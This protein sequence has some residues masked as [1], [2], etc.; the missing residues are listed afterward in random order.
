ME[1]PNRQAVKLLREQ[2]KRKKRIV[3]FLCMA[4][5]VVVGTVM[6]LR[7]SGRA[8]NNMV[9]DCVL[10]H[11]LPHQHSE[12]CYYTPPGDGGQKTL[13]C[14][15]ADFVVHKHDQENC[16][17]KNGNLVCMLPEIEE[18]IHTAECYQSQQV[19]VCGMQEGEGGHVHS[20][21]CY[22]ADYS[23]EPVCGLEESEGHIHDTETCYDD[24]GQLVC[25]L[26]ETA[27]HIH[28]DN[29]YP[30]KLNCGLE[31]GD[32]A[33]IHSDAC[34][35]TEDILACGKN[36]VHLHTHTEECYLHT[37]D[38]P[39]EVQ[40]QE[41]SAKG[42][43][44]AQIT[45]ADSQDAPAEENRIRAAD[46]MPILKCGQ[47]Q[48]LEHVH[49]EDCY[50][51]VGVEGDMLSGLESGSE[52]A[53]MPGQR[54]A[55]YQDGTLRA[56]A[57][58]NGADFPENARINVERVDES[59]RLPEKQ[60]QFSALMQ[61]D[62]IKLKALLK[63]TVSGVDDTTALSE[64]I[65]LTIEPAEQGEVI[66]AAWYNG[67]SDL[68]AQ[69]IYVKSEE[70]VRLLEVD[71]QEGN[72]AVTEV[73]P[74]VVAGFA[75][76]PEAEDDNSGSSDGTN[77]DKE[78]D[79][80]QGQNAGNAE[81]K[82]VLNISQDFEYE[83][84]DYMMVF[85]ISGVAHT[86]EAAPQPEET[87]EP[88]ESQSEALDTQ[89]DE[90]QPSSAESSELEDEDGESSAESNII[91]DNAD[92][93][94]FFMGD[95]GT[96]GQPEYPEY[97]EGEASAAPVSTPEPTAEPE[98]TA[99]P[100]WDDEPAEETVTISGDV[101]PANVLDDPENPLGLM[102][103]QAQ[104]GTPEYEVYAENVKTDNSENDLPDLKVISYSLYYKGSELD[105]TQCAVELDVTAKKRLI[106]AALELEEQNTEAPEE[107]G[108]TKVAMA[109]LVT[110]DIQNAGDEEAE[111]EKEIYSMPIDGANIDST[112]AH[113]ETEAIDFVKEQ[114][115]EDSKVSVGAA[116]TV[117]ESGGVVST[118]IKARGIDGDGRP[119]FGMTVVSAE[120]PSF[121]V[122]Y[123]AWLDK[124]KIGDTGTLDII[125]TDGNGLPQNGTTPETKK[126]T[127][128]GD[129]SVAIDKTMTQIYEDE[130][131]HYFERPSLDYFAPKGSAA[132][133]Y[134]IKQIWVLRKEFRE[135][136]KADEDFRNTV[137]NA[138]GNAIKT[139]WETYGAAC[140]EGSN[141]FTPEHSNINASDMDFT[142]R[143][144]TADAHPNYLCITSNDVIRLVYEP[145]RDETIDV[146][147]SFFDYDISDGYT[148]NSDVK[149]MNTAHNGINTP[150][151]YPSGSGAEYAF[152]NKN[153]GTDYGERDWNGNKLN[154]TNKP[155][156]HAGCTFGLV[157]GLKV[158][159]GAKRPTPTFADGV[160]APN[161][162]GETAVNGK[163]DYSGNLTFN[164]VGDT[165]TLSIA[166]VT[167]ASTVSGMEKFGHPGI[168]D[169]INNDKKIKIWTNH[170]W[171][172]DNGTGGKDFEFGSNPSKQKFQGK[173]AGELPPS[174]DGLDH[175]S[176]FGMHFAV[177]FELTE[178]YRGPLEYIFF[179]DDDMWVFLTPIDGNGNP[180]Y[181]DSKLICDIGGVH[182]SVGEMVN[183][184]DYVT[185]DQNTG[186]GTDQKY[187]LDFYYTERGAS[188][189]TCW[190]Q[191]T[192][193][194]VRGIDETKTENDYRTLSFGKE[195][196]KQTV[197]GGLSSGTEGFDTGEKFLF[198]LTLTDGND[199][200]VLNNFRYVK[201]D[202][203]GGVID[204][205]DDGYNDG[206]LDSR[207][208]F[209][210]AYFV[211][212]R[213]QKIEIQYLP[214][215]TKYTIEECGVFDKI[216]KTDTEI[217]YIVKDKDK[218]KYDYEVTAEPGGVLTD[219][220]Y[221]GVINENATANL[222]FI[223]T[224]KEFHLPKTGG[225]GTWG[226]T[227]AGALALLAAACLARRK[228]R[229]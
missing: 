142:N 138:T 146:K 209:N 73:S 81:I 8:M 80:N 208:L 135:Q 93:G 140:G 218:Q 148:P 55:T 166:S 44:T 58:Y 131:T 143:Q 144:E 28:D 179:G 106:D 49:G 46:G 119:S 26:E 77:D 174:D 19:L 176:Y 29:C 181:G 222:K 76:R 53:D 23:G 162:F 66:A 133:N 214:V 21:Q 213:G 99:Q 187:R 201:Y 92:S 64:P 37:V 125:D 136:Y 200:E 215:G 204:S 178:S 48:V 118:V 183:V 65:R 89:S 219:R 202:A 52:G 153:T 61:D 110:T 198:K 154:M 98:P 172:M 212:A 168:Y 87:P 100:V 149:T 203:H 147:A 90:L 11:D 18:H 38:H 157:N 175:N 39:D 31:E 155:I 42:I 193:P 78:T 3:A 102:V 51:A 226:F 4:G 177:E 105:L 27:A 82:T 43:D 115:K 211:L 88:E 184:W 45:F 9:L 134:D 130:P 199:K 59:E 188:G 165:H 210:G 182:S 5:V 84:E 173:V 101:L 151:N 74:G 16:R 163:T 67:G 190:M 152:G 169:G 206:Y 85:H 35:S 70:E 170:F 107:A 122:Q 207:V 164:K 30:K 41:L 104:E 167:G 156:G 7:M 86:K 225:A 15:M 1:S 32:G 103:E 36:D 196:N 229:R 113:H 24:D 217:K 68:E 94:L 95:T 47:I 186:Y 197:D 91:D 228:C 62:E 72:A 161:I 191:Y 20:D 180:S 40:T 56:T 127:L 194:S 150:G 63:V 139:Y 10:T 75:V 171:P 205:A 96:S 50:R 223:N 54:T 69:G 185:I 57:I 220:T 2:R 128:N 108:G 6:A 22:E 137:N 60:E 129:G 132:D 111:E 109:A 25:E 120:N 34:Y 121:T 112:L 116:A 33:H 17:D 224:F 189:S 192:L 126:L 114:I 141:I 14:G 13:V 195:V 124:A 97:D 145:K 12:A 83:D 159:E 216:E 123:Y 160:K 71:G 221:S 117:D 158:L 227:G 79:S